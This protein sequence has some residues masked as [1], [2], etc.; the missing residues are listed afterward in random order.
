MEDLLQ[1]VRYALRTFLRNPGFA[2][3][4]ILTL[5]LGIGANTAIFTIFDSV[6]LRKLPV[7]NPQQLVMLTDPDARGASTGSE[8]GERHLL[9]YS[10]FEYLRDH[11]EVFSGIFAADSSAVDLPVTIANASEPADS[12][13]SAY[14]P[15]SAARS[16]RKWTAR[17]TRLP[18]P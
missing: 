7:A 1:D 5:A 17:A 9:A 16:A 6:L 18:L 11:N 14:I 2:F 15:S 10:E 8:S 12:G 4:A 3:I 13:D